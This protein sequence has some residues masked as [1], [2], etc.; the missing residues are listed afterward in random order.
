VRSGAAP[1]TTPTQT[2]TATP[3][4]TPDGTPTD[5]PTTT[6][7]TTAT[8]TAAPTDAGSTTTGDAGPGFGLVAA[9][10]ALAFVALT[11]RRLE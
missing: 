4:E 2:P 6:D 7:T 8:A 11:R 1:E 3:T 9:T 10:L 5:A